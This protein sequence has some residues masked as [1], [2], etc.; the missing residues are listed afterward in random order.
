MT[1]PNIPQLTIAASENGESTA[2]SVE[3]VSLDQT[4]ETVATYIYHL[5]SQQKKHLINDPEDF[6]NNDKFL[7]EI[8][9]NLPAAEQH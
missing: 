6:T 1:I 3:N 8:I 4:K 7:K 5:S 2:T 9:L